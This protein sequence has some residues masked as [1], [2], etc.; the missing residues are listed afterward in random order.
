MATGELIAAI[1]G[2]GIGVRP[3]IF[4]DDSTRIV[5]IQESCV[6]VR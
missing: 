1:A 3:S 5:S 4:L 6:L 2:R